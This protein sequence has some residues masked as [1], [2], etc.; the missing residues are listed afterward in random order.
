[1]ESGHQGDGCCPKS[2]LENDWAGRPGPAAGQAWQTS[3]SMAAREQGEEGGTRA[4]VETARSAEACVSSLSVKGKADRVQ[5]LKELRVMR[6]VLGRGIASWFV[7]REK[8][9]LQRWGGTKTQE[10]KDDD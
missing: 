1:M 10:R 8:G 3:V 7:V 2:M 6:T 9:N 5:R 4:S